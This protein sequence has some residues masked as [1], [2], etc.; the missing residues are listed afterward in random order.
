MLRALIEA[1]FPEST[2]Q[3]SVLRWL[4][5]L[6]WRFLC[7]PGQTLA[8]LRQVRRKGRIDDDLYPLW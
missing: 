1:A 3:P 6:A 4:P 5:A 7:H 2:G 8:L